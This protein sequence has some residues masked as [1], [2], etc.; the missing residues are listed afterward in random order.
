MKLITFDNIF[1]NYY[2]IHCFTAKH[3]KSYK[4]LIQLDY[5]ALYR[6]VGYSKKSETSTRNRVTILI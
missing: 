4:V 1:L 2:L 3:Y 5:M 6:I